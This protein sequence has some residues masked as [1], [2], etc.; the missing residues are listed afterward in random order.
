MT[1]RIPIYVEEDHN[2][3]LQHILSAAGAKRIPLSGNVLVHLDSHPDMLIPKN[4]TADQCLEKRE[5]IA[6]VSIENWILPCAYLGLVNRI[7]WVRPPWSNQI[8]DGTHRFKIGRCG[9]VIKVSCLESYF[10]SEG[11]VC[12]EED[13]QDAKDVELLVAP[14]EEDWLLQIKHFVDASAH[15]EKFILDID[16]DFYSTRNPF[17]NMYEKAGMY[18][19]LKRMYKF[20]P[21]PELLQG[22]ERLQFA[23]ETCRE[24]SV[25]LDTLENMFTNL[26]EGTLLEVER[27]EERELVGEVK[28]LKRA[29]ELNYPGER[30][31]WIVVHDAGCTVD[32]TELPHHVSTQDEIT[33]LLTLTRRMM[34]ML[35]RLPAMVTVARSTLDDFCPPEQIESIQQG[36]IAALEEKIPEELIE[37]HF[38]YMT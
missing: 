21:V 4:L 1:K 18:D 8:R 16:L 23:I 30:V 25:L 32:D 22:D 3:V 10:L 11:I 20:R 24:R 2:D 35:Q 14:L 5:L 37:M 31:D 17:L 27:E 7:V 28:D 29:I 6:A 38:N 36:A 9:D 34:D 15:P 13:L 33:A 26:A 19:K 12:R